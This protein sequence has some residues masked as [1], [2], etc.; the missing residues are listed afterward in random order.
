M[1]PPNASKETTLHLF[2]SLLRSASYLP[3]APARLWV[4]EH[5]VRRFRRKDDMSHSDHGKARQAVGQLDR[6]GHGDIPA[7]TKVLSY[8]YG[9]GG[10]RRRTL[11][12]S[13]CEV[14]AATEKVHPPPHPPMFPAPK[15]RRAKNVPTR[16]GSRILDPM[17]VAPALTQFQKLV[18]DQMKNQPENLGRGVIKYLD[19][20]IPKESIWGRPPA[21]RLEAGIVRRWKRD[22]LEKMLPPLPEEEWDRLRNLANKVIAAE[23]PR[24]RRTRV[25]KWEDEL[26]DGGSLLTPQYLKTPIAHSHRA[27]LRESL[28]LRDRHH[29]TPKFMQRMYAHI[30]H[31]SP[32]MTWDSEKE[33]WVYTWGGNKSSSSRGQRSP[34]VPRDMQLF[35]GIEELEPKR[36][37]RLSRKEKI[38]TKTKKDI[39]AGVENAS[40]RTVEKNSSVPMSDIRSENIEEERKNP[41]SI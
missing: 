22:C 9:R 17:P 30:W 38:K 10:T 41:A 40:V 33:E 18:A 20:P 1:A 37:N 5:I 7:L 6:A 19:P 28:L 25:G 32:K 24:K 16:G 26:S 2:R 3:D 8:T 12:T 21:K 23:E 29:I 39:G 27:A 35:E 31:L 4:K 14:L 11:V 15:P 13:V 36:S 34:V